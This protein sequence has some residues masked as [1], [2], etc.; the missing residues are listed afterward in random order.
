[1]LVL[2]LGLALFLGI[3]STRIV[4]EDWRN[5]MVAKLGTNRWK[6]IYSGI[7][8]V[9]LVLIVV[10]YGI[11]QEHGSPVLYKPPVYLR[12]IA[13]LLMMIAFIALFAAY[14]GQK[15][16][17]WL[18][19]P[20]LVSVMLWALAH[21]LTTGNLASLLLFSTFLAW[22]VADRISVNHRVATSSGRLLVGGIAGDALAVVLGVGAYFAFLL[23][24][25]ESLIGVRL[26]PP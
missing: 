11:T 12:P 16:H 2:L 20:M 26:L 24:L 17:S 21:L 15:I 22:A 9:G 3:H 7:S 19:H 6:A 4:A 14:L 13:S 23:W 10:G 25:H 8:L 1:M 5:R 18:K